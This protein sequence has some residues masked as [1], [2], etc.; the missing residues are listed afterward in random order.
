M[1][2]WDYIGDFIE[3]FACVKKNYKWGYI[4]TSYNVLLNPQFDIALNF[5]NGLACV[6][7]NGKWGCVDSSGKIVSKFQWDEIGRFYDDLA[8]VRKNGKYGFI[9]TSG[10]LMI[11]PQW[12][13]AS[14]YSE[15]LARV[16]DKN[17][18][19][20]INILGD[21]VIKLQWDETTDFEDGQAHVSKGGKWQYIDALG[22]KI[23]NPRIKSTPTKTIEKPE[24]MDANYNTFTKKRTP[25]LPELEKILSPL[26]YEREKLKRVI[27][28]LESEIAH[29]TSRMPSIGIYDVYSDPIE[30]ENSFIH[31]RQKIDMNRQIEQEYKLINNPYFARMDY[32]INGNY[33][34]MYIGKKAYSTGD[35]DIYDWRTPIGHTFYEK[36]KLLFTYNNNKY[37]LMLR[38]SF[39]IEYRTLIECSEEYDCDSEAS[40]NNITDPFLYNKK[41]ENRLTDIIKT[42]Q[43]NQNKIITY[44]I[45]KSFI[46]Q[47]CAGSGKTM[48]L[49]HRLSYIKFNNPNLN[50][51]TVKI[52]TPS[53]DFNMHIDELSKDLELDNISILTV[54]EYY[55]YILKKY[56]VKHKQR[57]DLNE[58]RKYSMTENIRINKKTY[59]EQYKPLDVI[60]ENL[61][62]KFIKY[63]Y[64]DEFR[65]LCIRSYK[66][67]IENIEKII[68][69]ENC[70]NICKK[71]NFNN[72]LTESTNLI[73]KYMNYLVKIIQ[74][75]NARKE[76]EN[77]IQLIDRIQTLENGKIVIDNNIKLLNK[78]LFKNS[79]DKDE[80]NR[81]KGLSMQIETGL[82]HLKQSKEYENARWLNS[83]EIAII[84]QA[85]SLL[86]PR[87]IYNST[88]NKLLYQKGRE[89][90]ID[91][92]NILYT[93]EGKNKCY[94]FNL[95]LHLLFWTLYAGVVDKHDCYL[96]IDEGQDI[97]S[98][99]YKV[100]YDANK[101]VVFNIY[102]DVNQLINPSRGIRDWSE[103]IEQGFVDKVFI[104]NENYRN[105][106]EITEF[107][108]KT[109]G[110]DTI[111]IGVKGVPIRYIKKDNVIFELNRQQDKEGTR[112]AV[113]AKKHSLLASL[114]KEYT[115]FSVNVSF[116]SI[117]ASKGIE[118]DTV[119]VVDEHMNTNEKYISYT[120]ALGKLII[121]Q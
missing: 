53:Q 59:Y 89:F 28:S 39:N 68:N 19:G 60:E 61:D 14:N 105:C 111:S 63:I 3:G 118:F 97:S 101:N 34:S 121:A 21:L 48:V 46:L 42:I 112:I 10:D 64:S 85:E 18:W 65:D 41:K 110:F 95:Y 27:K 75:N 40:S 62:K 90:N 108:N 24:I 36:H 72:K 98:N 76:N 7:K 120:R 116:I 12:E 100:F 115:N 113:I 52:I 119:Y 22:K 50:L 31:K 82:R 96:N 17:K 13:Y 78:K 23:K 15:G 38:R 8:Y 49:L 102:G 80:I 86:Q 9:D 104:L 54:E 37:S 107:Y 67:Y 91:F 43:E 70:E 73:D 93:G 33:T 66:Y 5:S 30:R 79:K 81:L 94:R 45:N 114:E 56:E 57:F 20:Y 99:E 55:I 2:Q 26:E 106:I 92:A 69:F 71:Y 44:P 16:K 29:I 51:E 83:E 88:I 47:G 25:S 6:K 4:D 84:D 87:K 35:H 1:L 11:K 77:C 117:K 58:K 74:E 32:K 109:L 103:V